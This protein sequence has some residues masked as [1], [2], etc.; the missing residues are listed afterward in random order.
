MIDLTVGYTA[1]QSMSKW[2]RRNG[3]MLHLHRA[4]HGTYTRQKTHG[5]C[6]RVHRQVVSP[7]RRR[8]HPRRHRGRQ[9]RGR[10]G[11][12]CAATTTPCARTRHSEADPEHGTLLRPGLGVAARGH[13][14]GVRRDPRRPDAPAAALPRRGRRPAVRRRHH[15]PP[16]G[17]RRRRDRQPRRRR[18]DDPGPQRGPR[19]LRARARTSSPSAAKGCPQLDAA[20]DVWK[21]ITFDFESTDTP[22]VVVTPTPE[23]GGRACASPRGPSPTCPTSPTIRSRR[24]SATPCA[25]AG[26]SSVEH[27][28]DPHPRNALLG[29]VGPA[30]CSTSPSD[31]ADVACARCA[32]AARRM[33]DC[34]REGRSPTTRS[35]G[36]QTT[37]L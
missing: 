5:V 30:A 37:A 14:G 22:D 31:D 21:D 20:L 27:T 25:T 23:L 1:M 3:V 35:L 10:P 29:D 6:F 9:A 36:R 33:P 17:H 13:A 32:R 16:D 18:G 15:R 11:R 12:R 19:L 4:G 7:A 24:S 8:P 26:R 2:A 28:D 34:L